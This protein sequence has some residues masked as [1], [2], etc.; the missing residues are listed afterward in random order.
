MK[1]NKALTAEEAALIATGLEQHNS[2]RSVDSE[3]EEGKKIYGEVLNDSPYSH[4]LDVGEYEEMSQEQLDE[5]YAGSAY[6]NL[7]SNRKAAEVIYQALI[8]DVEVALASESNI[9]S[10][11]ILLNA[12]QTGDGLTTESC[13][14]TKASLAKWFHQRNQPEKAE[15]FEVSPIPE[16]QRSAASM[17]W[18]VALTAE[19]AA[20]RITGLSE[21]HNSLAEIEEALEPR[22]EPHPESKYWRDWQ[23]L[24]S[25]FNEAIDLV[26][27]LWDE[28]THAW[29]KQE[30]GEGRGSILVLD[31][32]L[33][34]DECCE[35]LSKKGC[36]VTVESLA[37][38][39]SEVG[40]TDKAK[41][42]H[43]NFDPKN[44]DASLTE[45]SFNPK[46]LKWKKTLSC[47]EAALLSAGLDDYQSIDAVMRKLQIY[48]GTNNKFAHILENRLQEA[49]A[50]QQAL[51]MEYFCKVGLEDDNGQ[52][53]NVDSV[54][55]TQAPLVYPGTI[56]D[57]VRQD[58]ERPLVKPE[59]TKQSLARWFYSFGDVN[60]ARRIK[61]DF[62]PENNFR[63]ESAKLKNS[64]LNKVTKVSSKTKNSY[65]RVIQALS[66]TLLTKGLTGKDS[67]DA[68]LI[69]QR[70]AS[71]SV[72]APIGK[73]ALAKY[74]KEARELP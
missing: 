24:K 49:K 66:K 62:D 22:N 44:L 7:V 9:G 40:G 56:L 11:L 57:M 19:E 27:I 73:E 3:I 30:L 28:I 20:L 43:P 51:E 69:L 45:A 50:V 53:F 63:D 33:Y 47:E 42:V 17:K 61:P 38:W 39:V 70:L 8:V 2:F 36:K 31:S 46:V 15:L 65:L 29:K 14:I 1:W 67:S 4:N 16:S 59:F 10:S 55:E 23:D 18:K 64:P 41:M 60:K 37:A 35:S 5:F 26:S 71:N 34:N 52:R 74:L 32:W 21:Y 72:E 48:K 6:F 12:P 25:D 54:L 68:Q 13:T 58:V